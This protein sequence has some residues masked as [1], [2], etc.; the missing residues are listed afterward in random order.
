MS[1]GVVILALGSI[2]LVLA[3][4]PARGA[5]PCVNRTMF[6]ASHVRDA[7]LDTGKLVFCTDDL[8]WAMD[9]ATNA[10][11]SIATLPKSKK[12][13]PGIDATGRAKATATGVEFC[14]TGPGSCRSYKYKFKFSGDTSVS[15]NAEGTLGAVVYTGDSMENQ[16]TWV[17]LYD[18]AKPKELKRMKSGGVEVFGKSFWVYDTFY[19]ASGKKLGKLAL[20]YDSGPVRVGSELVAV[21]DKFTSKLSVF[22]A[23][24]A[25][26]AWQSD[27]FLLAGSSEVI[28]P[29]AIIPSADAARIHVVAGAPNSG[30]VITVD[31]ASGKQLARVSPPVCAGTNVPARARKVTRVAEVFAKGE[32][33][34]HATKENPLAYWKSANADSKAC[35]A[36]P[37]QGVIESPN[38]MRGFVRC[39]RDEVGKTEIPDKAISEGSIEVAMASIDKPQQQRLRDAAKG[40]TIVAVTYGKKGESTMHVAVRPDGRI[41][42]VWINSNKI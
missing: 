18:L 34:V 22:N 37:T 32:E 35:L 13:E 36:L 25:K 1:R 30:E 17:M 15:I 8:C 24:T 21:T 6:Q 3:T 9:P 39:L 5:P 19:S 29:F 10:F 33:I 2:L 27:L 14:P 31:A 4:V 11:T 40:T 23:T 12:P 28:D 7:R 38:Q 20:D 26:L 16:P 42:A 41:T